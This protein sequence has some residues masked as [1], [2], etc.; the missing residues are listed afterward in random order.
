M[1]SLFFC[2]Q[3]FRYHRRRTNHRQIGRA[4]Q[5]EQA[6]CFRT[7]HSRCGSV[8][9][10][11]S[12]MTG[13]GLF[14]L[15]PSLFLVVSS[16]GIVGSTSFTLAMQKEEKIGGQRCGPAGVNLFHRRRNCSASCRSGRQPHS[17]TDGGYDRR[18]G[19]GSGT[20]LLFP[21]QARTE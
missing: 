20:L 4:H 18:V 7:R 5:C 19:C 8:S 1:F 6:A 9:T 15:M 11:A 16:I 13:M 2:D 3:R 21:G 10:L 17:G 14:A 12:I